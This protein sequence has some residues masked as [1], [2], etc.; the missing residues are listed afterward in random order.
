MPLSLPVKW[1]RLLVVI[2]LTLGT[3][4]RA[5]AQAPADTITYHPQGS[6]RNLSGAVV[7]ATGHL[8]LVEA[9]HPKATDSTYLRQLWLDRHL[10]P[11]RRTELRLRGHKLHPELVQAY[12]ARVLV[13]LASRDTL[14]LLALDTT[15]R[16]VAQVREPL[17]QPRGQ[18]D[19]LM[20][21]LPRLPGVLSL[22]RGKGDAET[23]I[24]YRGADLRPRW[25]QSV[26]LRAFRMQ[27]L[28]DSTHLWLLLMR[29]PTHR[30]PVTTAV[31]LSLATGA[32][33]SRTQL[34]PTPA[35]NQRI[36]SAAHLMPDHSLL[37][38][39]H[40]YQGRAVNTHHSGDL[41]VLRLSPAGQVL[42]ST[43]LDFR[44]VPQQQHA[45]GRRVAWQVVQPDGHG[46]AYLLGE[47]YTTTPAMASYARGMLSFFLL[48]YDV[49]RPKD[50]LTLHLTP[51]G[52]AE[53]VRLVPLPT[54]RGSYVWPSYAS[55]L[56][57]EQMATENNGFR[58]R[59]LAADSQTVVLRSPQRVQALNLRSG[60]L[61]QLRPAPAGGQAEVLYTG[62]DYVLLAEA[63]SLRGGIRL[64][65]VALPKA[66]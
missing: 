6:V 36:A 31:C 58:T 40:G 20:P 41:V 24:T 35:H 62:P 25:Q 1:C 65:R 16:L 13:Q 43:Q 57:M 64:V 53:Q 59:G 47:T 66:R 10:R 33:L 44:R 46:G 12:G 50:L 55:P 23:V 38:A 61:T 9:Q 26:D 15:G 3:G 8:L 4:L 21:E 56:A 52:Q 29:Y 49:L 45:R 17:P 27:L 11:V 60:Q 63:R 48:S 7:P 22:R 14:H 34:G 51:G 39:A 37:L 18:Y 28:A 54:D 32:E 30:H 5:Q 42:D 19:L 2:G